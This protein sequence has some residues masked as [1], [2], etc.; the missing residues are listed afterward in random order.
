MNTHAKKLHFICLNDLNLA[1]LTQVL[2][3]LLFFCSISFFF[4]LRSHVKERNAKKLWAIEF[5]TLLRDDQPKIFV[6]LG[7]A[8]YSIYECTEKGTI[9]LLMRF[10]DPD[11]SL[12]N[13]K[14]SLHRHYFLCDL[15]VIIIF[16]ILILFCFV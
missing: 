15:L 13:E 7:G 3:L 1:Q 14:I 8:Q 5:N 11:V 16:M 10:V 4:S 2:L 9:K 12:L 6:A